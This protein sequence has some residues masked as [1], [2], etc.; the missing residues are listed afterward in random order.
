MDVLARE[1]RTRRIKLVY[2]T[3]AAQLPTGAVL[4][5]ARRRTLLDLADSTQTPILEDDYDSEFRFGDPA[6]PALKT[7]DRAGQVVY[8]GTFSKAVM[9][10]LRLGYVVAARPLLEKLAVGRFSA[11]FGAD[12]VTQ[13]AMAELL[14]SGALDRHVR[15]LRKRAKER[16]SALLEALAEWMPDDV[17]WTTPSGGLSVWLTLPER[18]EAASFHAATRAAGIGYGRGEP[19]YFDGRGAGQLMLSFATQDPRRLRAGVKALAREIGDARD[20]KRRKAS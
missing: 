15:G 6:P 2:A 5:D 18:I 20:V 13:S 16:R 10:G 19:C 4:S 8:V 14:S 1:I 17:A 12:V 9:P 7:L 3:P 11:T